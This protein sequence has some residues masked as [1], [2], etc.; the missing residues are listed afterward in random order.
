[1]K[2]RLDKLFKKQYICVSESGEIKKCWLEMLVNWYLKNE[3]INILSIQEPKLAQ[4]KKIDF[5]KKVIDIIHKNQDEL[6]E[7]LS[8][9]KIS[10]VNINVFPETLSYLYEDSNWKEYIEKIKNITTKYKSINSSNNLVIEI[11]ETWTDA[12]NIIWAEYV[13]KLYQIKKQIKSLYYLDD[14]SSEV[15]DQ[16]NSFTIEYIYKH[17]IIDGFKIDLRLLKWIIKNILNTNY[18]LNVLKTSVKIL[19]DKEKIKEINIVFE[20]VETRSEFSKLMNIKKQLEKELDV[21]IYM[22]WYWLHKPEPLK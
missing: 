19:K 17:K 21:K 22:Q 1:M 12:N 2:E 11:L 20:G 4:N 16:Y 5:D 10:F 13:E 8:K 9:E 7:L 15:L 3:L 18:F 6:M 14:I